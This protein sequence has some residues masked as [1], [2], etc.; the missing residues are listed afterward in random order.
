M[1]RRHL[2]MAVVS[3]PF[4]AACGKKIPASC[5]DTAG[6]PNEDLTV[7][8]NL[9]YSDVSPTPDKRC[10]TCRQYTAPREEGSCGTCAVIKGPIHPNGT[11][12][13]YGARG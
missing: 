12:K 13:V 8:S 6:M 11:C 2:L 3:A 7:R 9:A 4:T 1:K 10:E 5:M